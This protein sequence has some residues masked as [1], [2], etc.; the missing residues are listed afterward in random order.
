MRIQKQK[1]VIALFMVFW[2]MMCVVPAIAANPRLAAKEKAQA[3]PQ[4]APQ[5]A[6]QPAPAPAQPRQQSTPSRSEPAAR[7]QPA[8]SQSTA[9]RT[10]TVSQ[11]QSSNPRMQ[12][13]APPT[14]PVS[15]P[16][17]TNVTTARP[18]E[19]TVTAVS[20]AQMNSSGNPR[21]RASGN[22]NAS[23]NVSSS[24]TQTVSTP[25]SVVTEVAPARPAERTSTTAS[26]APVNNSSNPRLRSAAG[27]SNAPANASASTT[28]NDTR[29]SE[30]IRTITPR[31]ETPAAGNPRLAASSK[32][33]STVTSDISGSNSAR[34]DGTA[35]TPDRTTERTLRASVSDTRVSRITVDD[36][37]VQPDRIAVSEQIA[38]AGTQRDRTSAARSSRNGDTRVS[39]SQA[40]SGRIQNSIDDIL[41]E[42]SS[43]ASRGDTNVIINNT[44]IN[45]LDTASIRSKS[46]LDRSR[47]VVD[48]DINNTIIVDGSPTRSHSRPYVTHR[49]SRDIS[50]IYHEPR[51]TSHSGIYFTF[52]W[53]SS[54]C[55][56]VVYLPYTYYHSWGGPVVYTTPSY[57][58]S[59]Y[60]P[61]YHRKYVFVSLGGYWPS[62]HYRRYYWY[63]CHPNYWYGS[64]I[65][66]EPARYVTYNI[67][68]NNDTHNGYGFSGSSEPYYTL[69]APKEQIVDEPEYESPADLCFDH[70]VAL[71]GAGNYDDAVRQFRE[72]V[73]LSPEDIVLPFTYSQALFANGNYA[74][75]VSVLREA[76]A[77]IP[78]DELTIYYPRG[79]YADDQQLTAQIKQLEK[80]MAAEPFDAD[81]QLLLGYQQLGMGDLDK[82]Y[83]PLVIASQNPAN[84]QTAGKL[85]ELAARLKAEADL[86]K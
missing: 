62:Y 10:A 25:R 16:A 46:G 12:A 74:M 8:P 56:Q 38:S 82:A 78:D 51:W 11:P 48:I 69:G 23:A 76:I 50:Y 66:T 6:P 52:S 43:R 17:T 55:G 47:P 53:S 30:V 72:A 31:T 28:H 70:G 3:Q 85:L 83:G 41:P 35:S 44:T 15:Q 24:T 81:Y 61:N 77:S 73:L 22:S 5:S 32:L 27:N 60:Y 64:T 18:S 54:T 19:R 49:L 40:E 1:L 75:A 9:Q 84:E 4:P 45:K 36:L 71:F 63:G 21:L 86:S 59:Y 57:G 39:I 68:T 7:T 37:D 80:A 14:A 13:P 42:R 34:S 26:T 2:G 79:L 65:I 58:L 33:N 67:Y 20:T 29:N